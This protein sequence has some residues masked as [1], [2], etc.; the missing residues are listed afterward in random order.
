VNELAR[1]KGIELLGR[2]GGPGEVLEA[3]AHGASVQVCWRAG[4]C[5]VN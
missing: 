2:D 5:V 3:F 4:E 1:E